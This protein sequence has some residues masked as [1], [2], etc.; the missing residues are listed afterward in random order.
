M[1]IISQYINLNHKDYNSLYMILIQHSNNS[2]ND[3]IIPSKSNSNN[4][5]SNALNELQDLFSTSDLTN[6][7]VDNKA[8]DMNSFYQDLLSNDYQK[9]ILSP[10]LPEVIK[11]KLPEI[12]KY[13]T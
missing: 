6:P 13:Y 7:I 9:P 4:E 11:Q 5:S 2:I 8:N 1:I 12:S 10:L 3:N